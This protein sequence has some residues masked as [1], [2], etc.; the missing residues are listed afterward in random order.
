MN[1]K[2]LLVINIFIFFLSCF[3]LFKFTFLNSAFSFIIPF[4]IFGG[5]LSFFKFNKK[6]KVIFF[7]FYF[8]LNILIGGLIYLYIYV[9]DGGTCAMDMSACT[10]GNN[11]EYKIDSLIKKGDYMV[12][13]DWEH[14]DF[15]FGVYKNKE[16][17]ARIK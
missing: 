13:T 6:L 17:Q 10:Y 14:D 2:N 3:I 4:V 9:D 1:N 16:K 12:A 15:L 7:I 5:I 11:M 8:I